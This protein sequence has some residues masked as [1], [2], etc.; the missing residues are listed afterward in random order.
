M[1][2]KN[3]KEKLKLYRQLSL[4]GIIPAIMAVGPLIGFFIG[5]WLDGK[6]DT[7]PYLM[8]VFILLGLVAAG[9]ETYGVIKRVSNET[10]D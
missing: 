9:K 2:G 5:K 8:W 3:N 7:E 10:D 6:F 4:I 1:V